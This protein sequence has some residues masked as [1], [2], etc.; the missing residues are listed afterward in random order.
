MNT[1]TPLGITYYTP[2]MGNLEFAYPDARAEPL[3]ENG[4]FM[5]T[6]LPSRGDNLQIERIKA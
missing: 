2:L 6:S 3:I 5:E 1:A 4:I